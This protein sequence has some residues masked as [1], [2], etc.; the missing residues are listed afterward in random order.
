MRI[1]K[2]I[3]LTFGQQMALNVA[4]EAWFEA[5]LSHIGQAEFAEVESAYDTVCLIILEEQGYA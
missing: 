2:L 5:C 1:S 4:R 3:Q